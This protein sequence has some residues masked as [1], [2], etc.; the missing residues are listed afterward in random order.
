M[1][2]PTVSIITPSLNREAFL[3]RAIES[4]AEQTYPAV[5]HIV[6]DGRSS[7]GSV[8]L[9]EQAEV[10]HG[11]RWVSEPDEGMYQAINKGLAM[12][13]GEIVAYLNSDDLYFPWSVETAVAA[14][15]ARPEIDVVYGDLAHVDTQTGRGGL[16]LYPPFRLGYLIRSAF[17]GQPTA[18]WRRE[19]SAA[20]HGFDEQFRFVADCDFWMRAGRRFRFLKLD[21]IQA[22]DG[23]HSGT[24]RAGNRDALLAE[25]R[26]VRDRNGA[27]SGLR[28]LALRG[29]DL[30]YFGLHTQAA[31]LGFAWEWV[32][33]R[34]LGRTPRRWGGF[35][36][37]DAQI[38]VMRLLL[39]LVPDARRR[40]G[41][42]VVMLRQPDTD[43]EPVR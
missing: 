26:V 30:G 10:R 1:T 16:R 8:K 37:S 11:V 43:T 15:E 3:R 40:L 2:R 19:V 36:G 31:F 21:E 38:S 7:D 12:A 9:L 4:V 13:S 42:G 32:R 29:A 25:L 24:L 6:V 17:I 14:F 20:L 23:A 35:L 28:G 5:E 27:E 22:V 41:Y 34:V 39:C 33:T 18:F